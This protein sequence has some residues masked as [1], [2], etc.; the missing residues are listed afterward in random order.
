MGAGASGEGSAE[1]Q[2]MS[3]ATVPTVADLPPECV[4]AGP[5]EL[6]GRGQTGPAIYFLIQSGEVV[7]VGQTIRLRS[8]LRG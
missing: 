7:Y 6:L 4:L 8:R 1:G 2:R 3:T 5:P